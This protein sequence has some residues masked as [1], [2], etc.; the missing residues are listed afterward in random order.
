MDSFQDFPEDIQVI[1]LSF[2]PLIAIVRLSM[3]GA[4]FLRCAWTMVSVLDVDQ[5]LFQAKSVAH[6]KPAGFLNKD[7]YGRVLN[8]VL[9]EFKAL[10]APTNSDAPRHRLRKVFLES[11]ELGVPEF[12]SDFLSIVGRRLTCFSVGNGTV[13]ADQILP[14]LDPEI[15]QQLDVNASTWRETA[16]L[17][18]F[19]QRCTK[20]QS[21]TVSCHNK[22]TIDKVLQSI[23]K[24]SAPNLTKLELSLRRMFDRVMP[25]ELFG[26]DVAALKSMLAPH[27]DTLE[28]FCIESPNIVAHQFQTEF[29]QIM[30]PGPEIVLEISRQVL[31]LD[32]ETLPD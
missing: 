27:R 17:E 15:V 4:H 29:R 13:S 31:R 10:E 23:M 8:R 24:A 12:I 14:Y 26:A 7:L 21:L 32:S 6:T 5:L 19:L 11:S 25:Q 28:R 9:R 3:A 30:K 1:I 20:L 16:C 18:K 22:S 2:V